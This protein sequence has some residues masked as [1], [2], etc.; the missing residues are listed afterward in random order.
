M[1]WGIKITVLY[2]GFVILIS[3]MVV[4]SSSNKSELVATDYYEQELNYQHRIDAIAN[5]KKLKETIDYQLMDTGIVLHFPGTEITKDFTGNILLF[6]P[7][8]A[9]KDLNLK[10]A[11]NPNG[12]QI[13]PKSAL[14]KGVYKMCLTWKNNSI[15]YYKETIITI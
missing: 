6:R 10:L 12:E 9:S 4:I 5:E 1:S 14:H 3:S 15:T 11:F 13:I 8:D 7:S 2:T